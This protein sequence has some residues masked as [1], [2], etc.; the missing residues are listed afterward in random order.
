VK[1]RAAADKDRIGLRPRPTPFQIRHQGLSHLVGQRQSRVMAAFPTDVNLGASPIDVVQAKLNDVACPEPQTCQ[2]QQDGT[3]AP[4]D[5]RREIARRDEAFHL[6]RVQ[7]PWESGKAPVRQDRNR[8]IQSRGASAS[9]IRN[10]RNIR[11]AVVH[12]LAAAHPLA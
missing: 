1:R 3:I 9:A 6:V 2:E 8:R 4:T 10:R 5:R 7:V 12:F 11:R